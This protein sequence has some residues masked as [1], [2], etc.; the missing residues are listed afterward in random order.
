L[1]DVHGRWQK[2]KNRGG[3]A[4]EVEEEGWDEFEIVVR[5]LL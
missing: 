2:N 1:V 4:K 5:G 3:G